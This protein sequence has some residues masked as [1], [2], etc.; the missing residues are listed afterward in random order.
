MCLNIHISHSS[1]I[2][3]R[4]GKKGN[5][6]NAAWPPCTYCINQSSSSMAKNTWSRI[7]GLTSTHQLLGWQGV[8]VVQ[9]DKWSGV[10]HRS[11]MAVSRRF[12]VDLQLE[13]C[14]WLII[15]IR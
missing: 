13:L 7:S 10:G 6:I 4:L 8:L 1:Q 11:M 9:Q 12:A 5:V 15:M 2:T 3:S 14:C